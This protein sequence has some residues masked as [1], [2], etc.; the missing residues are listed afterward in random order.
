M[1][2]SVRIFL[3]A[4]CALTALP[5]A[6]AEKWTHEQRCQFFEDEADVMVQARTGGLPWSAGLRQAAYD[7]SLLRIIPGDGPGVQAGLETEVVLGISGDV[8]QMARDIWL[9]PGL[10]EV[11]A[12]SLAADQCGWKALPTPSGGPDQR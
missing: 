12:S 11:L 9:H 1:A 4:A 7:I 6:A 8:D 2:C 5:A 10:G 3:I